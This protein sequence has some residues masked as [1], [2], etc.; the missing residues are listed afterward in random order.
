MTDD[1]SQTMADSLS[2]IFAGAVISFGGAI[3]LRV[4]GLVEKVLVARFFDPGGYGEIVLGVAFLN[5]AALLSLA[6]LKTGIVRYLPRQDTAGERSGTV[7][8]VL[9]FSVALGLL[10]GAILFL[11][12]DWI[13]TTI[14]QDGS[15]ERVLRVFAIAVPLA[16]I[17]RTG[18]ATAQGRQDARGKT[19]IRE[20]LFPITRVG[21]V[22]AAVAIGVSVVGVSLAYAVGY[23]I[24]ALGALYYI[25]RTIGFGPRVTPDR[26]ELLRFSL[27]LLFAGSLA[28]VS[29]SIDTLFIGYFLHSTAVGI[30]NA[31]Y[32]LANLVLLAPALF[33]VV[34]VPLMSM[35]HD[36][37]D[38]SGMRR[39]YKITT[40]WTVCITLP[41]YLLMLIG[42]E[43]F[44]RSI[45][46]SEYVSGATALVI[47]ATGFL[48]HTTLGMNGG[49]LNMVGDSDFFMFSNLVNAGLNVFLNVFLIPLIGI[50]GAALAT[51]AS[52]SIANSIVSV[53]LYQK[54]MIQPLS[55][56]LIASIVIY[57]PIVFILSRLV[58]MIF[59]GVLWIV[60]TYVAS[61]VVF[62][63]C[64]YVLDLFN[65]EE[66][67]MLKQLRS[68][69]ADV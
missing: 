2:R 53:R 23:G 19:L 51:A 57:V 49:V 66:M 15:M 41:G 43:V 69:Y 14:L 38:L 59:D 8:F 55:R 30:Y 67:Q 46:G 24:M 63:C 17:G 31:A 29:D 13:S 25:H 48:Y 7:Y 65:E 35:Y 9:Q 36:E 18:V 28:F 12:A 64:Y 45:F 54:S 68:E 22:A 58:R 5:L 27:P 34:F 21:L 10:I 3:I 50:T 52:Y 44:I 61:I 20:I 32:P 56:E 4:S 33:G 47:V 11:G 26:R 6:G 39:L 40:R 42:P 62:A 1:S 16:V 60:G 37:G